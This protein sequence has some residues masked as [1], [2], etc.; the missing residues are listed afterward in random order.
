MAAGKE[1]AQPIIV[2]KIKKGG[3]GHHGGAWKVA[4]A[5]FVT[6][7]MAFFLLL[8]LMGSTSTE[9]KR[10][11]AGYFQDPSGV[12][13]VGPGG[14][15][16]GIIPKEDPAPPPP[17]GALDN[18]MSNLPGEAKTDTDHWEKDKLQK[19]DKQ[20][21]DKLEQDIENEIQSDPAFA[22]LK[23]QIMLDTTPMGL[24]IHILDKPNHPSFS[25][26]SARINDYTEQIL[27]VLAPTINKVNNR[28]S[29]TGHTDASPLGNNGA[30]SN[31]ELS[32]DRANAARRAL[33]A[34]GYPENKIAKVEGFADSLPLD[35]TDPAS[36]INR[37]IAILILRK[38][39]DE[40]MRH[41]SGINVTE[42]FKR[43]NWSPDQA[44]IAAPASPTAPATNSNPTTIPAK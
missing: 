43:I 27:E 32:A 9:Q 4:Y 17:Q 41:D 24:R 33:I 42:V 18:E 3:H 34:G 11:I 22:M 12:S 15:A 28:I 29:I 23:D 1:G 40:S 39:I 25:A 2:K 8:W 5:D 37:R 16:P 19:E 10:Y 7:M 21:L 44:A 38:D 36:P 13:P 14:A 30:Y 31:W 20:Q 6:A 35:A 26:G